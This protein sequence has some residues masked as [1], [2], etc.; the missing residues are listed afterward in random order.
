MTDP[1]PKGCLVPKDEVSEEN[2]EDCRQGS[3]YIVEGDADILEAQIVGG[4]HRDKHDGEGQD[5]LHSW[6]PN[7]Q[8]VRKT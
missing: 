4:D 6:N 3:A 5:L 8:T 2:V 1:L 7:F